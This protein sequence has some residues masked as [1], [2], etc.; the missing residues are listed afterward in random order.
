MQEQIKILVGSLGVLTKSLSERMEQCEVTDR[1]WNQAMD[2]N[3]LYCKFVSDHFEMSSEE[4]S[5]LF[6]KWISQ[7]SEEELEE[8]T[9]NP[10]D[11]SDNVEGRKIDAECEPKKL[12]S[13]DDLLNEL[14][15]NEDK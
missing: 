4:L 9:D 8:M 13:M 14:N 15:P 11:P 5:E 6:D 1:L 12:W 3:T 10:V 7:F 2:A